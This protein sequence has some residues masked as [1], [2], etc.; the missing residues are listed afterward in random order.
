[1][2][3][4]SPLLHWLFAASTGVYACVWLFRLMHDVNALAGEVRLPVRLHARRAVGLM[5]ACLV[6]LGLSLSDLAPE[7][8]TLDLLCACLAIAWSAYWGWL[9]AA[10]V[11]AMRRLG[12]P[13]MAST[14]EY[15][16]WTVLMQLSLPLLQRRMNAAIDERTTN[17]PAS[18]AMAA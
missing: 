13:R 8:R 7:S 10:L 17:P 3:R 18:V 16:V 15:L 12:V 5:A 2:K 4:R 6:V 11:A 1:M 9:I 14:G